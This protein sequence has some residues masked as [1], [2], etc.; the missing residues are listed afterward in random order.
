MMALRMPI[1]VT[2][3]WDMT[4]RNGMKTPPQQWTRQPSWLAL[5][6][7]EQARR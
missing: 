7:A 4:D 5:L 1:V 3:S 6:L 2:A